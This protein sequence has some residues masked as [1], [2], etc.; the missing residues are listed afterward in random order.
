MVPFMPIVHVEGL[1]RNA[2]LQSA[3]M[4]MQQDTPSALAYTSTSTAVPKDVTVQQSC[5]TCCQLGQMG[6]WPWPMCLKS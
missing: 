2:L 4:M 3:T 6:G 1:T 5:R